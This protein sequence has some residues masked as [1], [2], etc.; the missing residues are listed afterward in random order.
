MLSTESA[1]IVLVNYLRES[2]R[3]C[4]SVSLSR[5]PLS[6]LAAAGVTHVNNNATEKGSGSLRGGFDSL[7]AGCV[8]TWL[9]STVEG[10]FKVLMG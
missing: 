4:V 3:K 6:H 2:A 7:G 10:F 8:C 5:V 1:V 9:W